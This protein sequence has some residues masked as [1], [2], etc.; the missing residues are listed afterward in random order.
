M[1]GVVDMRP[2]GVEFEADDAGAVLEV[3]AYIGARLRAGDVAGAD[4]A[5]IARAI[6][7]EAAAVIATSAADPRIADLSFIAFLR[8]IISLPAG[9][10]GIIA[11]EKFPR[12][13]AISTEYR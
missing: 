12:P 13:P 9:N 3:D 2:G 11:R 7:G 5:V 1:I 8:L 10:G 6:A 4:A